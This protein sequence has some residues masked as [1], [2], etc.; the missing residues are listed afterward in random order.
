MNERSIWLPYESVRH[1]V[2]QKQFRNYKH[3][4]E[5]AKTHVLPNGVPADPR[6]TYKDSYISDTDFFGERL[7]EYQPY[8]VACINVRRMK[9]S[10]KSEYQAYCRN[11]EKHK[12]NMKLPTYP[13][14]AYEKDFIGWPDFLGNGKVANA[15]RVFLPYT[16]AR[17]FVHQ[18]QLVNY[19][20]WYDWANKSGDRPDNIPSNPW[21]VYPEWTGIK[22]WI[23]TSLA[24]RLAG[25]K[26]NHSV[27]CFFQDPYEESNVFNYAIF[28]GGKTQALS[29]C[30]YSE[31]TVVATFN[32]DK[33]LSQRVADILTECSSSH[34]DQKFTAHNIHQIMFELNLLLDRC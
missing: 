24:S 20:G 12:S 32:H 27:L 14:R 26:E 15:D 17:A 5:Y 18:L 6:S 33:E 13:N 16:E 23:G 10:S 8:D 28:H 34:Y 11:N 30:A 4:R 21:D 7:P 3:F 1:W 31:F 29:K 9:F 2:Q 22:D 25:Q 19:F